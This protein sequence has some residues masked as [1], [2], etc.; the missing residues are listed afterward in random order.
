M[1][2]NVGSSDV[3]FMISVDALAIVHQVQ[4]YAEGD[5]FDFDAA[6][7]A[8]NLMGVDNKKSSARVPVLRNQHIHL[9]ADSPSFDVFNLIETMSEVNNTTYQITGVVTMPSIGKSFALL[10][11]TLT[12]FPTM[13]AA[14]Q[15]LQPIDFTIVWESVKPSVI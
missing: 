8:V 1:S 13:P 9:Q 6:T 7:V 3:I 12:D 2:G 11:G 14:K 4:G 15:Y 5:A 10:N